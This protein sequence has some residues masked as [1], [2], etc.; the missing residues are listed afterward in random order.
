MKPLLLFVWLTMCASSLQAQWLKKMTDKIKGKPAQ[1]EQA[2]TKEEE[3]T[4]PA[5]GEGDPL[6]IKKESKQDPSLIIG[7]DENVSIDS[8]F[9]FD[10]AVYQE[11]AAFQGNQ[12]VKDGGEDIVIYYS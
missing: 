8:S 4:A 7:G 1:S 11:T 5:E 2:Q 3:D 9:E 10:V 6:Y 12:L